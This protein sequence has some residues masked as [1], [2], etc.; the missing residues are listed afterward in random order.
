MKKRGFEECPQIA[1]DVIEH[2]DNC[3]AYRRRLDLPRLGFNRNAQ[4]LRNLRY[5]IVAR[6]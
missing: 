3:P 6:M 5:L 2:V 4:A 1:V